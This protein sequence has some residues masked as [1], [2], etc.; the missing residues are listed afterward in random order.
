MI[1][2]KNNLIYTILGFIIIIFSCFILI[3]MKNETS[4]YVVND[5][6]V[7]NE[8]SSNNVNSLYN[9]CLLEDNYEPDHEPDED[10]EEVYEQ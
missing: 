6:K 10:G 4:S 9:E 3:N 1:I 2:I 7:T 5:T 8:E